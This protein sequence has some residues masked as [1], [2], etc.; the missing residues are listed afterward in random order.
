VYVLRLEDAGNVREHGFKAASLA[1]LCK[2]VP[3]P[4]GFV[5][6][7]NALDA[8][9]SANGDLAEKV[10]R[11]SDPS[12][13]ATLD[14]VRN[15]EN[16]VRSAF[17]GAS[18]PTDLRN[19]IVRA[20][21]D[22]SVSEDVRS[23]GSAFS[24][25]KAGRIHELVAVRPSVVR[26]A[27]DRFPGML[28]SFI[29]LT[30]EDEILRGVKLCWASLFYPKAASYMERKGLKEAAMAVIV[31]KMAP[32]EKSGSILTGF[33]GDKVLIEASWG[34]GAAVSSGIVTPDEYLF[35]AA[36]KL[37]GKNVE[38]KLWMY[39]RNEYTGVTS[40]V[41]VPVSKMGSQV[42]TDVEMNK[43]VELA[44][45]ISGAGGGQH[46]IDWTIGRNRVMI[47]DAK[48]EKYE[49]VKNDGENKDGDAIVTGRL[50]SSGSA[51]GKVRK[52]DHYSD[53]P[54]RGSVVV[55]ESSDAGI[56]ALSGAAAVV[57]D[58]GGRLCNMGVLSRE[59]SIPALSAAHNARSM[60]KDGDGVRIVADLESVFPVNVP[61]LETI[62]A[63]TPGPAAAEADQSFHV[64][65]VEDAIKNDGRADDANE[66]VTVTAMEDIEK[67]LMGDSA[68]AGPSE[69]AA[70]VFALSPPDMVGMVQGADGFI[71][72]NPG[73]AEL[74]YGASPEGRAVSGMPLWVSC[75]SA[76]DFQWASGIARRLSETAPR[77]VGILVTV[78]RGWMDIERLAPAMPPGTKVGASVK[79]PAMMLSPESVLSAG[80]SMVNI[81]IETLVQLSMGLRRPE[82]DLHE[83]VLSM[84]GKMAAA[85]SARNIP[86]CATI[87]TQHL[88]ERNVQSLIERGVGAVC[89][90]P[91][92]IAEASGIVL[93]TGKQKPAEKS[94]GESAGS[95]NSV[96][97]ED[98]Q[99]WQ[100]KPN[101][102]IQFDPDPSFS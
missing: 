3:V 89:V 69:K 79:T 98:S 10:K 23:A 35:D 39:E 88:T 4:S 55:M 21:D 93:R 46:I 91:P 20:Y 86:C 43:L 33:G 31:Q 94:P 72:R 75:A 5:I 67:V 26:D 83:S 27:G 73:N 17:L 64:F 6:A 90:E 1:A 16:D 14:D 76:K 2:A 8:F 58:E 49:L 41:Y 28:D 77:E 61:G 63:G 84:V 19:D 22:L 95:E 71:I 18:I 48:P 78:V 52:V 25:I 29:N 96:A 53:I 70:M 68:G 82:K 51:K 62:T 32:A 47:T 38:K 34:P 65:P 50:V 81:E 36:G 66:T 56:L 60:L 57:S 59:F 92:A 85:C 37:L 13:M 40:K 30:G 44:G 99:E 9:L 74:P 7:R 80:V 54:K 15:A 100:K 102:L 12:R 24:I 11:F 45:R 97:A 42:L 87:G 101:D